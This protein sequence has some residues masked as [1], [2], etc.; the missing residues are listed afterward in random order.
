MGA[1]EPLAAPSSGHCA[2]ERS[3]GSMHPFS[4]RRPPELLRA[5]RRSGK[6]TEAPEKKH[7]LLQPSTLTHHQKGMTR[8]Q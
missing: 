4:Q 6:I 3:P 2:A 7:T 1:A 8:T 5:G